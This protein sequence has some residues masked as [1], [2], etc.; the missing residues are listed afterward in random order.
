MDNYNKV[1]HPNDLFILRVGECLIEELDLP[2]SLP[3]SVFE[4][5]LILDEAMKIGDNALISKVYTK[6]RKEFDLLFKQRKF[7]EDDL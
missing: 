7:S 3:K 1:T 4:C 5:S 6:V 2:F